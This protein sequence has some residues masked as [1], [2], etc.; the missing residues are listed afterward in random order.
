M[1]SH[2]RDGGLLLAIFGQLWGVML[3][4]P[5]QAQNREAAAIAAICATGWLAITPAGFRDWALLQ[6]QW[7]SFAAGEGISHAGDDGGA[8]YVVAE[9]QVHFTAGFG[10]DDI[11]ISVIG[12]PGMWFGLAPLIGHELVSSAVAASDLLCGVLPRSAL[13]ARLAAHPKDWQQMTLAMAGLF[14]HM[15]GAHADMLISDSRCRVAATILRLGGHRHRVHP[16]S[17][18]VVP[19]AIICTQEQLAGAVALSRNTTGKILRTL[20][21]DGLIDARYGRIAIL[22]AER[23]MALVEAQGASGGN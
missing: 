23:M 20:E 18:V 3:H 11:G 4:I 1:A 7:R 14:R 13:R 16:L 22:N 9:G 19:P 6:L 12:L 10:V 8:I 21:A 2:S 15:A 17:P 5:D